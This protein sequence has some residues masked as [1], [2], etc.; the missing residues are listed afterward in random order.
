[1]SKLANFGLGISG[2]LKIH[3]FHQ[4]RK[5]YETRAAIIIYYLNPYIFTGSYT[6]VSRKD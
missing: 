3:F 5:N 2:G 6:S 1:M 4:Q